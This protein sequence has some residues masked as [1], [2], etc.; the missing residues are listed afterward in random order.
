MTISRYSRTAVFGLGQRYA[1]STYIPVIRTNIAN[2][3]I[4]YE[5]AVLDEAERL[6]ALAGELYGDG[7]LWWILAAA[8]DI[9]WSPQVPSG[10]RLRI[11]VIEDVL[12]FI[13]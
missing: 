10:T 3:N 12:K 2:G 7:R 1:T 5:E 11:P 8:S 4:R 6:D 9:G 13:G